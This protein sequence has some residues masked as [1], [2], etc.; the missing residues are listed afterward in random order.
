MAVWTLI[1]CSNLLGHIHDQMLPGASY[2]PDLEP[3][4]PP[5]ITCES[6]QHE[7]DLYSEWW[8]YDKV[9]SHILTSRLSPSVLGTIPIANSLLGQCR[10]ARMI[11]AT[12]KNNYGAGDY[13]A[14]MAIKAQLQ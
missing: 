3:S 10:S 7:K 1:D 5:I 12:L 2:D 8:N 6:S 9:A 14:V 13:S 4:F 11:C